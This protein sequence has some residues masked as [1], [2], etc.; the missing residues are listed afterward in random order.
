[1]S[2]RKKYENSLLSNFRQPLNSECYFSATF[3]ELN[4]RSSS[5]DDSCRLLWVFW[6]Y[7]VFRYRYI[8]GPTWACSQFRKIY[9][10][11]I[12]IGG[13]MITVFLYPGTTYALSTM[14]VDVARR[15]GWRCKQHSF[16]IPEGN[17]RERRRVHRTGP[18]R[19]CTFNHSHCLKNRRNC[20]NN[21]CSKLIL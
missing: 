20:T 12:I 1:M 15:W 14:C 9:R 11:P 18:P 7:R 10:N 2:S 4:L 5:S 13:Y 21:S 19:P 8:P 3:L 17:K 6:A 16:G